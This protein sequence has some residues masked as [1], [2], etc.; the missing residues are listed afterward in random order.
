[1]TV[2]RT[3][4][5]PGLSFTW[6]LTLDQVLQPA[7]RPVAVGVTELQRQDAAEG[8]VHR[9]LNVIS[10]PMLIIHVSSACVSGI[11]VGDDRAA[12]DRILG[13]IQARRTGALIDPHV[14]DIEVG[15][16]RG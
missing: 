13:L 3:V 14:I 9:P 15:R 5:V 11:V 10:G 8:S 12:H 7:D 6:L 16:A 1:M 4:L 2:S